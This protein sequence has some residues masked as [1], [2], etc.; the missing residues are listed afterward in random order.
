MDKKFKILKASPFSFTQEQIIVGSLLGKGRIINSYFEFYH[1]N[2]DFFQWKCSQF[3]G[4]INVTRNTAKT[5]NHQQLS[6]FS[7]LFYDNHK[8]I[9]TQIDKWMTP[10]ALAIWVSDDGKLKVDNMRIGSIQFS[11]QE[12]YKLRDLLKQCFNLNSKIMGY[13]MKQ[14][15]YFQIVLNKENTNKLSKIVYPYIHSSMKYMLP[16]SS[17]TTCQMS[18]APLSMKI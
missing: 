6:K 17:E 4:Y 1:P 5:I 13:K 8:K 10:L 3:K 16:E 11:E 2:Q 12:N 18:K 9:I 7:K 15:E 14:K